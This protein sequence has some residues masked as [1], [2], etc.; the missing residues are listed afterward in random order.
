MIAKPYSTPHYLDALFRL[1]QRLSLTNS[2]RQDLENEYMRIK[3]GDLGE[4]VVMDSLEQLQLPYNFYIFHNLNLLIESRI[5]I[6]VF[7]LTPYYMIIFEVKNI[8]GA[9]ELRQNPRQLVRT[10]QDGE[11]H[12]FNSPE[13]QLQEYVHQLIRFFDE[14]GI[15][16]PIYGAIVFPFSSSFIKQTSTN[17]TILLRNEIKPFLRKIPTN[18]EYFTTKELAYWKNFFIRKHKEFD[19]YPLMKH[20]NIPRVNIMNGVFCRDCGKIGMQ[21]I[22]YYWFCPHCHGKSSN[23][24]ET[25]IYEYLKIINSYITNAECRDFLRLKDINKS[26]RILKSMNLKKVG[27]YKNAKYTL[28]ENRH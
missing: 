1:I 23:G 25:A 4:K 10:L 28:P 26:Y 11:V 2:K 18:I 20:Y 19:P 13:P 16:I 17:S 22:A 15:H 7:L 21:R 24:H 14:Y 8:K 6:D 5:Q 3:A 9:I 12:A 27:S